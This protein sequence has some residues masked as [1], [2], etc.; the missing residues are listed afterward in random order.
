MNYYSLEKIFL[1]IQIK[2]K[3]RQ[4][5]AGRSQQRHKDYHGITNR[6]PTKKTII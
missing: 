5:P 6:Y 3:H 1:E 4:K 2:L